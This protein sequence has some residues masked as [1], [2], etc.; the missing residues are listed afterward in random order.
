MRT[1]KPPSEGHLSNPDMQ[2]FSFAFSTFEQANL[3]LINSKG[4]SLGQ[5]TLHE[6]PVAI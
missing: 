3:S 1:G 2:A 6:K 5:F 4:S